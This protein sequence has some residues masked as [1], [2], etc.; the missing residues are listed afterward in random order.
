MAI[1]RKQIFNKLKYKY[2]FVI[3]DDLSFE[4]KASF[5]LNRLGVFVVLSLTSLALI[6]LTIV[7]IAFT[8]IREYIPG[9]ADLDSKKYVRYLVTKVDSLEKVANANEIYIHNLNSVID[10]K[11]LN[12]SKPED[13]TLSKKAVD[14]DFLKA[15]NE[16]SDSNLKAM[17][18]IDQL[19][20]SS[21]I[22]QKE[23]NK[24]EKYKFFVP[25]S[26]TIVDK[27]SRERKQ[28]GVGITSSK[29]EDVFSALDGVLLFS[30][31]TLESGN[32]LVLQHKDGLISV[33]KNCGKFYKKA[34]SNVRAGE[35]IAQTGGTE[36]DNFM[37]K[38]LYFELWLN[39]SPL[40]PQEFINFR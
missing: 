11:P 39:G 22:T 27:Y 9:Y 33:Y 14:K 7:L 32:V 26:G 10:G 17:L 24:F 37:K 2:R 23:K 18:G 6:V 29:T 36:V 35:A 5:K 40:N 8:S 38:N 21:N 30:G 34:G 15:E 1:S 16:T 12:L 13:S 3:L 31:F 25:V 28:F 20:S 4:E 19:N